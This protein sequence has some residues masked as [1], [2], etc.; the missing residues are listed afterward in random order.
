[1]FKN[2]YSQVDTISDKDKYTSINKYF[3]KKFTI[4]PLVF[5][6]IG[7]I[8]LFS[9]K[10]R[11]FGYYL[12][13]VSSIVFYFSNYYKLPTDSQIDLWLFNKIEKINLISLDQ[14]SFTE[15][16]LI[17]KSIK[18]KGPIWWEIKRKSLSFEKN[19]FYCREGKK[20]DF[21]DCGEK[22]NDRILRFS[23]YNVHIFHFTEHFLLCYS[24]TLDFLTGNTYNV[25]TDEYYY[26]D[27]VSASHITEST[28][29]P[30]INNP[31]ESKIFNRVE[32]FKLTT[33][34]GSNVKIL[35]K[36]KELEESF[37]GRVKIDDIEDK[38]KAIR[39]V[40]RLKKA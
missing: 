29:Y 8:L 1:M 38:I 27:I 34:G 12:V 17:R 5:F 30:D 20:E 18:I 11:L 32:E 31:I 6:T 14:F 24:C 36:A 16:D 13:S 37:N 28:Y 22:V 35:L 10:T 23:H 39:G 19:G 7:T 26:K 3:T 21:I 4:F 2:G 9:N 33:S 15:N 40:L 25:Q